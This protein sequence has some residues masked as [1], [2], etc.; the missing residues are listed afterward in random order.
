[1]NGFVSPF[2][3][4]ICKVH[5]WKLGLNFLLWEAPHDLT[6]VSVC[7]SL[8]V[9]YK[10]FTDRMILMRLEFRGPWKQE[11]YCESVSVFIVLVRLGL[12]WACY[13][14]GI[15]IWLAFLIWFIVVYRLFDK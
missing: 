14:T 1:M 9:N 7:L 13:F 4:A 6:I 3:P 8:A 11:F 12:L 10:G 5:G 2:H 15:S